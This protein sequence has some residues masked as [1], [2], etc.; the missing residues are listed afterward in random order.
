M[1]C[2]GSYIVFNIYSLY[3]LQYCKMQSSNNVKDRSHFTK[4][5]QKKQANFLI[6]Q[7]KKVAIYIVKYVNK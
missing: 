4:S 5:E 7:I 2:G 3:M 1:Y 6:I